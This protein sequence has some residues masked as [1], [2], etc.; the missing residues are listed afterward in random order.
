MTDAGRLRE[1]PSRRRR[2]MCN[3]FG[4]SETIGHDMRKRIAVLAGACSF[5]PLLCMAQVNISVATGGSFQPGITRP[6]G[7]TAAF[8]SRLT[9][10][11]PLTVAERYPRPTVMNG[12]SVQVNGRMAPILAIS[13]SG[14]IQQIN[15][16]VA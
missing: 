1:P 13:S 16:H 2:P 9:G 6:G 14:G 12:V 7:I 10:L 5:M 3:P 8:C 4:K 11:P 15:F